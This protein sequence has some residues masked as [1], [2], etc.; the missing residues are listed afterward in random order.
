MQETEV[1][2]W[3]TTLLRY[4]QKSKPSKT[5]IANFLRKMVEKEVFPFR[6]VVSVWSHLSK[7]RFLGQSMP[8]IWTTSGRYWVT[9]C[10]QK[11]WQPQHKATKMGHGWRTT[12]SDY[13]WY[14]TQKACGS[15]SQPNA[16]SEQRTHKWMNPLFFSSYDSEQALQAWADFLINVEWPIKFRGVLCAR[17]SM[18]ICVQPSG[19]NIVR[20]ELLVRCVDARTNNRK[21]LAIRLVLIEMRMYCGPILTPRGGSICLHRTLGFCVQRMASIS[22]LGTVGVQFCLLMDVWVMIQLQNRDSKTSPQR[23]LENVM[24]DGNNHSL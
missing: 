19:G 9:R 4:I 16:V 6:G 3:L 15:I 5:Q 7:H 8:C 12:S 23:G 11:V 10:G 14:S 20:C 13:K 21:L 2:P 22:N 24:P 1:T 17:V 18:H